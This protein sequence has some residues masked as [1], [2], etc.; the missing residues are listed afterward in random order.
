M[1]AVTSGL[2]A[3]VG[4]RHGRGRPR[5]LGAA[6]RRACELVGLSVA[7]LALN[8]VVGVTAVLVIR[9]ATGA[10]LSM[11]LNADVTLV[12]LSVLQAAV[13]QWWRSGDGGE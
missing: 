8:L 3:W 2:A 10:F 9:R 13:W 7:F 5:A 6:L 1:V 4:S 12:A 11:Y